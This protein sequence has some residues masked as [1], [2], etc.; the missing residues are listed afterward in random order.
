MYISELKQNILYV[1]QV[2][3]TYICGNVFL[4]IYN[5]TVMQKLTFAEYKNPTLHL[6]HYGIF[7]DDL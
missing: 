5:R 6:E 7:G 1:N 3:S 4:A 2:F